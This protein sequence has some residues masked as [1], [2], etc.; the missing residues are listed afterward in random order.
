MILV[1]GAT[2]FVGRRL[3]KRLA[4]AGDNPLRATARSVRAEAVPS[5]VEA[6]PADVTKPESLPPALEGVNTV[7]HA[8]AITANLKE[9]Y[10][11]A[12]RRI[13]QTGTENLMKAAVAAGVSRVV[14]MSGISVPAP[15]GSYMAT[16]L[17]MEKAVQ[18]SGIPYVILQ[19]SVLFGDG[20]EFITALAR[21]AR[22]SPVLPLMG[23]PKLKFQPLWIEDLLRI[24]EQTVTS[25]E[26]IGRAI[27]VGGPEHVTFKA[28]LQTICQA[29]SIRRLLVPL[30]LPIAE[31]QARVMAAVLPKPPLTPATIELFRYDNS[32]SL[33]SVP[34]NFGF[35]P[36]GFREHLL[37]HGVDR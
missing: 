20:A 15:E 23:D 4:A 12:Y 21:V 1:T 24:L 28:V 32:T 6:V 5:G 33:D 34:A 7:V 14:L 18:D 8:A 29:M 2:G 22:L 36:R 11:G 10:P 16:R 3:L 30:P 19:P 26:Y 27:P 13:N 9:P 17:G 31:L 35:Q 25:D 37:A